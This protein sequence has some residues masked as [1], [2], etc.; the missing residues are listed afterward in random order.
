[1]RSEIQRRKYSPKTERVYLYWIR[2][3]IYFHNKQHPKDLTSEDVSAFLSH[4]VSSRK[5]AGSTQS[6]ALNAIVY[7]YKQVLGIDLGDLNFLRN[8]KVFK[9]IPTVLSPEEVRQ[10]FCFMRGTTKLMACLLYGSGLRVNECVTLRVQDIDIAHKTITVRNTKGYKARVV[11]IPEKLISSLGKYLV[12]RKQLHTN[13]LLSGNGKVQL[14]DAL[15]RKYKSAPTSFAWQYLFASKKVHKPSTSDIGM[16]WHTSTTTRQKALRRAVKQCDMNKRVTCHTL[17]HSFATQ[18]LSSGY[19]IRT[20]QQLMGH[21][22]LNTT[23]IYTHVLLQ[24]TQSVTS[25]LDA[26]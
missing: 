23:M 24:G 15:A 18:L 7:L 19:D 11:M 22:D 4:L 26:L 21:K 8:M 1:M 12:W 17:R 3:Y 5:V 13:D 25:P 6:R 16:R 2:Q 14:P 9:N 10:I 20:I